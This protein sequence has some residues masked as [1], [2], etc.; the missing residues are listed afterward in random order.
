MWDDPISGLNIPADRIPF[1]CCN[2]RIVPGTFPQYSSHVPQ[3]TK[4]PD[5]TKDKVDQYFTLWRANPIPNCDSFV[6]HA[7]G[8]RD[9]YQTAH[10]AEVS[11]KRRAAGAKGRASPKPKNGKSQ[12]TPDKPDKR[13]GA[14]PP[15]DRLRQA[16]QA[17]G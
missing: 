10:A 4:P 5:A 7:C 16:I 14:R 15:I 8:F 3:P 12:A 11:A 17:E 2:P 9:W 6:Y 13:K 1:D